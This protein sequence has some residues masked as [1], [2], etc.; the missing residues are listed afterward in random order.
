M[1]VILE[2]AKWMSVRFE[3]QDQW[4]HVRELLGGALT[5]IICP[6]LDVLY[7]KGEARIQQS[8]EFLQTTGEGPEAGNKRLGTYFFQRRSLSSVD[9]DP[10]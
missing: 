10:E 1:I 2:M 9:T 7:F 8:F 3:S 5:E 4:G 6:G